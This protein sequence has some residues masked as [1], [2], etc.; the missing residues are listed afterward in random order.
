MRDYQTLHLNEE[1]V[2]VRKNIDVNEE[3]RL[4]NIT[5]RNA[6]T[7]SGSLRFSQFSGC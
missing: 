3:E 7:K 4:S 5:L 1:I 2:L 6:C